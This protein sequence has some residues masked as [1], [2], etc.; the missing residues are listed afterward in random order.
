MT[1]MYL[2]LDKDSPFPLIQRI[3]QLRQAVEHKEEIRFMEQPNGTTVCSYMVSGASTFDDSY[4]Q[5][6]RG[7]VFGPKG[8]VISRPLHKFFNVN[9][10]ESTQFDAL[11][12]DKVVRIMEK[13]DGSMI[14]TVKWNS[15][16]NVPNACPDLDIVLHVE[17]NFTLKS[18]KSFTSD[19]VIAAK[20]FLLADYVDKGGWKGEPLIKRYVE[21]GNY[22]T[23]RDQTGI[24][25][26]T[27]PVA[28]I[29]I[30]Y[31]EPS[32]HLLHVRD[33][34]TGRYMTQSELEELATKFNVPLVES[35]PVIKPVKEQVRYFLRSQT[36]DTTPDLEG[37]VIQFEN[38]DMVKLK[39][40]W[41]MDRHS[42]FTFLRNRDIAKMV[43]DE[44]LD[45]LKA[46]LVGDGIDISPI[47]QI[48]NEVLTLIRFTELEV[49][50]LFKQTEGKDRKTVALEFQGQPLF[51]LLM[52]KY[53]GKEPD[54]KRWFTKNA[55]DQQFDLTQ[56][57]LLDTVGEPE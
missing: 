16:K 13:R 9:E 14:H 41:Y 17:A 32:L 56:I 15:W 44:T 25:E 26:F 1:G 5:E 6:C 57:N 19:V 24:F 51:G 43:L 33:N 50:R 23:E 8:D 38:G 18:K 20:K 4:A 35:V 53:S 11:D 45:D 39:T 12:W 27:S 10:R 48:E 21:L 42:A 49:D 3:E 36:E 29:V 28:R 55:L 54:V 52:Q 7:I 22:L 47:L 34:V 40:K 30:G 37:W 31:K 46:K 2:R